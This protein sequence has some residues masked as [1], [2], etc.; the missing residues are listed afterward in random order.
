MNSRCSF[1]RLGLF[2]VM[3]AVAASSL[4]W[5]KQ[6]PQPTSEQ[7]W[8]LYA[9]LWMQTSG[10]YVACCLQTY[11]LAAVQLEH[12]M[13]ELQAK[14]GALRQNSEPPRPR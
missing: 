7:C 11:K 12:D 10:E 1:T 2:S 3:A 14:Q 8:S 5:Q 6:S 13:Q 4:G 9:D